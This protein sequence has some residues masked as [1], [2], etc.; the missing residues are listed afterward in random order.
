MS[1]EVY[2]LV[3]RPH[4]IPNFQVD[5]GVVRDH[6]A[7]TVLLDFCLDLIGAIN[8]SVAGKQEV[9]QIQECMKMVKDS[10]ILM[11]NAIRSSFPWNGKCSWILMPY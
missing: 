6:V 5:D 9:K 8:D 10:S 7:T 3:Y 11:S 1:S 4:L 2:L